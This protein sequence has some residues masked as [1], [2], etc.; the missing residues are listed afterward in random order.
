MP[1]VL[2]LA[3]YRFFFFANEGDEPPHI[4]VEA[5][6]GLAKYW[7][8]PVELASS[9]RFKAHE[10]STLRLV[11]QSNRQKFLEAWNEFFSA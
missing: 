8:E 9:Q 10:L 4:H 2:R 7:L 5:G 1:T 6:D 3:G 11:I